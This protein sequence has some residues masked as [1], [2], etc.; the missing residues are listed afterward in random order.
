MKRTPP[1]EPEQIVE[2]EDVSFNSL[3]GEVQVHAPEGHNYSGDRLEDGIFTIPVRADFE[4]GVI[5]A[6]VFIT[7]L[8]PSILRRGDEDV[9]RDD[10]M[11][12]YRVMMRA[13]LDFKQ[14]LKDTGFDTSELEI[15]GPN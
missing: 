12:A 13:L 15:E 7:N 4:E 9:S 5:K 11:W 1:M 14:E 2:S 3:R 6:E 8:A 10:W